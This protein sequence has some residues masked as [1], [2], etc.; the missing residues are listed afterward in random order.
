MKLVT[1]V[2]GTA[3]TGGV[4]M[5][6]YQ[7]SAELARRGH[8]VHLL[9]VE[10]GSFEPE[11]RRFCRSVTRV[12]TVDY[13]YPAGRRGRPRQMA[14]MV[15]AIWAAARRR[16]DVIYGNRVF[17]NGW[18]IP[19]GKMIGAPVVCHLHGHTD[20]GA[21]RV[22]FL[23]RH[24]G[25]FVIISQ[26]VADQWLASGL[27]PAKI[28][29][30]FNG[31]DPSEYAVGGMA[32]RA[33]ARTEL[34]LPDDAFVVTYFGRVDREKGVH[35][36]LEAWRRLGLRGDAGRLLVV[37]SS[38]V[39]HDGGAYQAELTGLAGDNVQFLGARRDVVT[40]LHAADVAVVPS[41]WDEPFGRTVIE[42]LA[43]GRPVLAARVGGI[44]EILSGPLERFL[45]DR[46]DATGLAEQLHA[47]LRW[48]EE[49]PDL[50]RQCEERVHQGFTLAQMV[51]GIEAAFGAAI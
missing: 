46:G 36:L 15:P 1:N 39:D 26:F 27:D 22:A 17:S 29:I 34:G 10:T 20:L 7:A 43:T 13:W 4:E 33:K 35:I 37:G 23:N 49:E 11:Y 16:P 25:R 31:I 38:M 45:F 9:H 40:P 18:A 5:H 48:R 3:P 14:Q 6:V 8:G 2:H 42:A 12:P 47:L 50:A 28:D 51:D 41:I 32:E 21:D 24:V 19:A 44:P 30:V